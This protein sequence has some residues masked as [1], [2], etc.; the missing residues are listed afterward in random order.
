MYALA[1]EQLIF[2]YVKQQIDKMQRFTIREAPVAFI[3]HVCQIG[4]RHAEPAPCSQLSARASIHG[5][6]RNFQARFLIEP[7]PALC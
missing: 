2:D 7:A 3:N 1:S 6:P 4:L 5:K